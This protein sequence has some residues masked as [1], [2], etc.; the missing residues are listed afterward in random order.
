MNNLQFYTALTALW[1]A[2]SWVPYI[3]DRIAIRG[4]MGALANYDPNARPQSAWAQRAMRAHRVNVEAFVAFGPLAV[5]AMILIP[6]DPYPG[7]LA[8]TFFVGIV[9]HYIIYCA[10]IVVLRT[11]AFAVAALSTAGL[12][13]RVL[14][15]I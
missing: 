8:S 4:L 1:V 14:G 2:L 3:L 12:A 5:M 9:A 15:A 7:L 11:L 6:D 10:G 13:L